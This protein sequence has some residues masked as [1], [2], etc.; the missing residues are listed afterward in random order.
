MSTYSGH[1]SYCFY[2]SA[3]PATPHIWLDLDLL[4]LVTLLTNV[5]NGYIYNI[6]ENRGICDKKNPFVMSGFHKTACGMQSTKGHLGFKI[7]SECDSGGKRKHMQRWLVFYGL[8]MSH[9]TFICTVAFLNGTGRP[10]SCV[11]FILQLKNR[12][13][14]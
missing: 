3:G 5:S 4:T 9:S 11:S 10:H 8:L 6:R 12:V 13:G 1:C 7:K 2:I 14:F